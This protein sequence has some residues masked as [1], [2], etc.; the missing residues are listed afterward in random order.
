VALFRFRP[1]LEQAERDAFD[2]AVTAL[3]DLVPAVSGVVA[4]PALGLQPGGFD[5][6]LM[7]DVANEEAFAAYK[8]H[9]AHLRLIEEH[10]RP[11][12]AETARAQLRV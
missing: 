8:R 4:R 7:I 5:Y 6:V 10:I 12:V 3:G 1:D 2:V 9:P 11:C